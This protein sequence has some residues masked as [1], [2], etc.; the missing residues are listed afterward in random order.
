MG[1]KSKKTKKI[2]HTQNNNNNK[3]KNK[4]KQKQKRNGTAV[5]SFPVTSL[6]PTSCLPVIEIDFQFKNTRAILCLKKKKK[7]ITPPP[8]PNPP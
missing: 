8:F 3:N 2:K 4:Q 6:P 1:R 5:F 7:K